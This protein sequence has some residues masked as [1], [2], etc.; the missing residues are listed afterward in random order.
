M[1]ID[2]LIMHQ[3]FQLTRLISRTLNTRFQP[4][5][6]HVSEWGIIVTLTDKGPMTQ[7]ELARYLN[8][9][10]SAVSRSLVGLQRKGYVAR[11]TGED[12]RERK[13]LLTTIARQQYKVWEGIADR[14]RQGIMAGLTAAD[15]ETLSG[16]LTAILQK[17]QECPGE[18]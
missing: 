11:E 10:P 14:H 3:V 6:L 18:G 17:A 8:I 9:E 7:R 1:K 12:R 15:K 5:D 4:F 16:I 13:V 2:G